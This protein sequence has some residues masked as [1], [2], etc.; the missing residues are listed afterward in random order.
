M[1]WLNSTD[2]LYNYY[3]DVN[4]FVKKMIEFDIMKSMFLKQSDCDFLESLNPTINNNYAKYFKDLLQDT[5]KKSYTEEE[6]NKTVSNLN[7][8]DVTNSKP[9]EKIL[10]FCE[11]N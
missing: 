2:E 8:I 5:Y 6:K 11:N 1:N 3:L 9:F 7:S 10:M 4:I